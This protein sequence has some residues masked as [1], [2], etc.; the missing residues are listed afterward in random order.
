MSVE[1]LLSRLDRVRSTG[2]GRW[3][4][5][6]PAHEDRSP[7]LSIR[8]LA[9]GRILLHDFG[10]CRT[11]DVLSA[12]GLTMTDLFPDRLPMPEGGFRRAPK[13]P[14]SDILAALAYESYVVSIIAM[15]VAEKREVSD[16]DFTRL[17]LAARRIGSAAHGQN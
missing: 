11:D 3:L 13:I 2:S 5:C 16:T 9:D 12:I 4:A 8:E 1:Q 10:G 17:A 7:S 14:A 6:C 15:Q